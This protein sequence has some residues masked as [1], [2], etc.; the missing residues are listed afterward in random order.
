MEFTISI[1]GPPLT[2]EAMDNPLVEA[3]VAMGYVSG[4]LTGGYDNSKAYRAYYNGSSVLADLISP[5]TGTGLLDPAIEDSST[6]QL[7]GPVSSISGQWQFTLTEG[8]RASG[9]G[10]YVATA[11]APAPEPASML[12]LGLGGLTLLR[13]RKK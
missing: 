9:V 10:G 12:L 5:I 3:S 8:G 6:Q 7:S 13:K 2:F 1:D 11:A 4:T